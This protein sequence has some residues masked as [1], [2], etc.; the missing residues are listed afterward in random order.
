LK[1]RAQGQE[2]VSG[3]VCSKDI[4][5]QVRCNNYTGTKT[6]EDLVGAREHFV[7]VHLAGPARGTLYQIQ[8][9]EL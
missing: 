3:Q 1:Y 7:F 9:I 2:N 4:E 6:V 8:Q 5:A